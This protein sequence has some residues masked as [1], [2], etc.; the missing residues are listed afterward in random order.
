MHE[1]SLKTLLQK[2]VGTDNIVPSYNYEVLSIPTELPVTLARRLRELKAELER[3]LGFKLLEF[4]CYR[5]ADRVFIPIP[6]GTYNK[7]LSGIIL[8]LVETE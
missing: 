1:K 3:E 2:Q 4:V 5:V 7:D 8:S 6:D